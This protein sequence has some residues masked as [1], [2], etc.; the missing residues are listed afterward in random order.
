VALNCITADKSEMDVFQSTMVLDG[1]VQLTG[2]A[3]SNV[4]FFMTI[5]TSQFNLKTVPGD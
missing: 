2:D 1:A 3:V 5:Q 4:F